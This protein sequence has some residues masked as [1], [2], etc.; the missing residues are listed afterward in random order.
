MIRAVPQR[1]SSDLDRAIADFCNKIGTNRPIN[2]VRF[3]V[4][5][6]G[7]V[8]PSRERRR[9]AESDLSAC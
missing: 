5:F 7:L 4:R 1:S 9:R 8:A 6:A 3:D 2:Y